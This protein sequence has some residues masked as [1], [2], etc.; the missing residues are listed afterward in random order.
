MYIHMYKKMKILYKWYTTFIQDSTVYSTVSSVFVCPFLQAQTIAMYIHMVYIFLPIITRAGNSLNGFLSKS[1]AWKFAHRFS[2]QIPHFL[3]NNEEMW[4]S[5]Q[6]NERF[7]HSLIFGE[8]PEGF[9]HDRSFLVSNLSDSLT[10]LTR[11]R[12]NEQITHLSWA[13]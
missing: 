5:L 7:A 2:E 6:K 1:P 10:S 12:G 4:N 11:K 13:T 3:P 9:A 8:R